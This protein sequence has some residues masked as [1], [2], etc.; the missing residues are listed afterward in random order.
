MIKINYISAG[1]YGI[2]LKENT[3]DITYKITAVIHDN[4]Y[5]DLDNVIESIFLNLFNEL[6]FIL[7]NNKI[8]REK[9]IFKLNLMQNI[10]TKYILPKE[11][12][13][14][15]NID[16][17]TMNLIKKKF[18]LRLEDTGITFSSHTNNLIV[19]KMKYYK[20]SMD[21][22]TKN[23]KYCRKYY[24]EII[25]NIITAIAPIHHNDFIHGDLKTQN[26]LLNTYDD[27]VVTDLGSV[28]S[29]YSETYATTCTITT[30]APE[31]LAYEYTDNQAYNNWGFRTDIWSLG[32]IFLELLIGYNPILMMYNNLNLVYKKED[33]IEKKI[34]TFYKSLHY[35]DPETYIEDKKN[36]SIN[37]DICKVIQVI[38][39]MLCIKP[40][41]RSDNIFSI[42]NELF[43]EAFPFNYKINFDYK[44]VNMNNEKIFDLR[45]KIYPKIIDICNLYN[46]VY[47]LPNLL[48][49][50]D[51]YLNKISNSY[52]NISIE[53]EL[54][55]E[56]LTIC[57]IFI[58]LGF[59]NYKYYDISSIKKY[60]SNNFSLLKLNEYIR[61]ILME[62][63]YDIYRPFNIYNCT[64]FN[65][66]CVNY[67][68]KNISDSDNSDSDDFENKVTNC[69]SCDVINKNNILINKIFYIRNFKD[70]NK[71]VSIIRTM[72]QN[73]Y[74]GATPEYYYNKLVAID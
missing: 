3:D 18:N 60:F 48:D 40:E 59:F 73:N 63:S 62:L 23:T 56:N 21:L 11:L 54:E 67:L 12:E 49:L 7:E 4:S 42:Y 26:I 45:K 9:C 58:M 1:S 55:F 69:I 64:K 46:K 20:Y 2:V 44:Y 10:N 38:K 66:L 30:R 22:I 70:K 24:K 37:M 27:L 17:N 52:E 35:I 72:I 50:M 51:R 61:K 39:S 57:A 28:R 43:D 25:K 6:N 19:N 71:L 34:L 5:I 68:K 65:I 16:L 15:F 29:I 41:S 13:T 14:M 31:D 33:L 47:L 8:N 32:L 36:I 74:I 53:F